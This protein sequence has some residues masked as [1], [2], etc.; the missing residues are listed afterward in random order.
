VLDAYYPDRL[1]LHCIDSIRLDGS[2]Q[3]PPTPKSD[4]GYARLAHALVSPLLYDSLSSQL[5]S[6]NNS[7]TDL[8]HPHA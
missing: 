2:D 5:P 3:G 7:Q 1:L 6:D 8:A 4:Q